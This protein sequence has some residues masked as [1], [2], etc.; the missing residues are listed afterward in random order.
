MIIVIGACSQLA[1]SNNVCWWSLLF[2][3]VIDCQP[4]AADPSRSNRKEAISSDTDM[5]QLNSAAY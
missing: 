3:L 1:E 2:Y 4:L 5:G